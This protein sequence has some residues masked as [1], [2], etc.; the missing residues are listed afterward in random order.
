[1]GIEATQKY[2]KWE[3]DMENAIKRFER[4]DF[5]DGYDTAKNKTFKRPNTKAKEGGSLYVE[6]TDL[7]PMSVIR[8]DDVETYLRTVTYDQK[9]NRLMTK[10]LA[11]LKWLPLHRR[12]EIFNDATESY[13]KIKEA[14]VK[15]QE[16]LLEKIHAK[17]TAIIPHD[18]YEQLDEFK[19]IMGSYYI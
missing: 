12:F 1:V 6:N 3:M 17:G 14:N 16:K 18:H 8:A 13:F 9:I 7:E 4:L 15:N 5:E 19:R 10:Y 2:A 11:R